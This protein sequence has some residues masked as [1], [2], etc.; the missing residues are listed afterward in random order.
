MDSINQQGLFT[1]LM[2]Y[3]N[4]ETQIVTNEENSMTYDIKYHFIVIEWNNK[5]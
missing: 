1:A 2:E 4:D 3:D 5:C